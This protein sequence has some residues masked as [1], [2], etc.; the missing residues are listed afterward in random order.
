MKET[1][2]KKFAKLTEKRLYQSL[3]FIKKRL[4]LSCYPL[5]FSKRL[6]TASFLEH[7]WATASVYL[8]PLE[9][10]SVFLL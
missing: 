2:L 7:L 6:I 3:F 10:R 1:V 5:N 8:Y 9:F 4:Q